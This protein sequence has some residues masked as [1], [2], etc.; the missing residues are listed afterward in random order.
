MPQDLRYDAI[1]AVLL[2]DFAEG[3]NADGQFASGHYYAPLS[4]EL[5][6][7]VRRG[8]TV[9]LQKIL[10]F[11]RRERYILI[12]SSA[13]IRVPDAGLRQFEKQA[14]RWQPYREVCEPPRHPAP[15]R[16]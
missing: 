7:A 14:S 16:G 6:N 12:Y 3:L 13:A 15:R 1:V 10:V 11:A 2:A 5:V 9:C 8:V 4:F